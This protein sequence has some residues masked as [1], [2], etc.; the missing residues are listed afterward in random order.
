[1]TTINDDDDDDDNDDDDDDDRDNQRKSF[2]CW[3]VVDDNE[4]YEISC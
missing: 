2:P 4:C 1:M 3:D